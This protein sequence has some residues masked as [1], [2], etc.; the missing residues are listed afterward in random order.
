MPLGDGCN[1]TAAVGGTLL[2]TQSRKLLAFY[3]Q[4]LTG[5]D[6]EATGANLCAP[7]DRTGLGQVLPDIS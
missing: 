2:C 6:I 3:D 7:R 5:V 1:L 4:N